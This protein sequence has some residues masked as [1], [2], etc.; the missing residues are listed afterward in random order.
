[1]GHPVG[2]TKDPPTNTQVFEKETRDLLGKRRP[3][4]VRISEEIQDEAD[5]QE[6]KQAYPRRCVGKV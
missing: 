4:V 1:M 5:G 6:A 3:K 2:M